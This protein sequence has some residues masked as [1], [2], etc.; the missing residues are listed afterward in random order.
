MSDES[1]TEYF[2]DRIEN[3]RKSEAD[4]LRKDG[5]P[6]YM[7]SLLARKPF[8]EI[9]DLGIA[10]GVAALA[11][12][13]MDIAPYFRTVL[14]EAIRELT[15]SEYFYGNRD[16]LGALAGFVGYCLRRW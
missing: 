6:K 10:V 12:E 8:L 16:K 14:P 15:G 13:A 2:A 11:G 3:P 7:I 4:R 1:L 5:L 9:A